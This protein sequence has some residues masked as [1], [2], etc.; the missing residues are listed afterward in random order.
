MTSKTRKLHCWAD[1][2]S[3]LEWIEANAHRDDF[4]IEKYMSST[5]M[6]GKDHTGPHEFTPDD[7]IGIS[8]A[9]LSSPP[10]KRK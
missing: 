7:Q 3:I 9:P 4:D 2:P 1:G 10:K 8:F 6:L 5:C